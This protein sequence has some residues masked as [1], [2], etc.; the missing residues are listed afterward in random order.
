MEQPPDEAAA[1]KEQS[2]DPAADLPQTSDD[3]P[4]LSPAAHTDPPEAGTEPH[5]ADAESP[6]ADTDADTEVTVANADSVDAAGQEAALLEAIDKIDYSAY[7]K[8]ELRA[9]IETILSVPGTVLFFLRVVLL[10]FPLCELLITWSFR[11]KGWLTFASAVGGGLIASLVFA[12]LLGITLCLRR[13]LTE[14]VKVID[15][16]LE[17]VGQVV[18]DIGAGGDD[19]VIKTT[20][21]VFGAVSRNL[22]LPIVESVVRAQLG[23]F[24]R[25]LLW[26]YRKVFVKAVDAATN[27][28]LLAASKIR[29]PGSER[30]AG[31]TE[32]MGG[33]LKSGAVTADWLLATIRPYVV[34]GSRALSLG[35]L[36]PAWIL[37]AAVT[38][39]IVALFWLGYHF[40]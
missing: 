37:L 23:F 20:A 1:S 33:K 25:P 31:T 9:S 11:E 4:R 13:I 27:R 38:I 22:V 14:M 19:G 32:S 7:E 30:L 6:D 17:I 18:A 39:G 26:V 40:G 2:A 15:S 24:G 34:G 12:V 29:V 36:V 8:A 10:S 5:V 35:I 28:I 16:T 3:Q 21:C